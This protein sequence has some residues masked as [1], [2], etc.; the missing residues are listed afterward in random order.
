MI[1]NFIQDFESFSKIN[2]FILCHLIN[3]KVI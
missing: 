1:Y 2:F 3:K